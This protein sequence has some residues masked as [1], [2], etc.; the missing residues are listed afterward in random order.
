MVVISLAYISVSM[1]QYHISAYFIDGCV[2]VVLSALWDNRGWGG[3]IVK[4]LYVERRQ[5][6]TE[7]FVFVDIALTPGF[8]SPVKD[9]FNSLFQIFGIFLYKGKTRPT[10][11][12]F[13]S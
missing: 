2:S 11:E 1:H 7:M 5:L 10:L 6:A 3:R 12:K 13:I 9:S 4:R 8:S